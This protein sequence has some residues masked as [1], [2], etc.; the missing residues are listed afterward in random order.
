M[1]GTAESAVREALDRIGRENPRINAFADVLSEEATA[2]ARSLDREGGPAGPLAGRPFAAKD[3]YDVAGRPTRAGSSIRADAPPAAEDA[4]AVARLKDAG[5][6]LV[7]LTHMDEFAYGFTG[8]N[9]HYGA[10]RNP[11]DPDRIAGGSSSGSGA[12]VASGLVPFALGSDTNGSVRVPA[13]LCG[14]HGFKPT[15]GRVSRAGVAPL[16]WSFDHAGVLAATLEDTAAALDAIQGPD[17]RDPAA[18]EETPDPLLPSIG[19]GVDGLRIGVA[20][21][22]FATGGF[23]EVFAAVRRAAECLDA[24]RE[25]EIPDSERAG[26]AALLITSAEAATLHFDEI[27]TRD[28]EFDRFTRARWVAATMIP[29]AWVARAQ[30]FRRRYREI[31]R[32]AFEETDILIAPTTPFPPTKIGQSQIEIDGE[33]L[34]VR[35]TLG[36]FTAPFSFIGCPALSVPVP[37]EGPF[38]LGVQLVAAPGRDG[39][40]L[41]AASKLR[42]EGVVRE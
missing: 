7:G 17:A 15:Y 5:A 20:G 3:L 19:A 18:S 37:G 33:T 23:T 29:H 36:R 28:A 6:I 9:A 2:D 41:R 42:D 38:P 32:A 27:R 13:A 4:T 21:G 11:R 31:V 10:V 40:L 8:E 12:A 1:T 39:Y 25:V 35:G 24:D 26:P 16:A 30:Q 14:I 22:H 34:P